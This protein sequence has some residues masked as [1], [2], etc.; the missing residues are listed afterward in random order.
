[1]APAARSLTMWRC[2]PMA[3]VRPLREVRVVSRSLDQA[4]QYAAEMG[5]RYPFPVVAA[6]DAESALR[7]ADLVVTATNSA[8]PV[9]RREWIAPG[10]HI[11]AV[12]AFTPTT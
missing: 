5:A 1:M 9:L 4:K 7:G 8:E 12:G 6:R 3:A 10:T 11:N 2:L